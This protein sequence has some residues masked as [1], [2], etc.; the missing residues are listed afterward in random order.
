MTETRYSRN[1]SKANL[2]GFRTFIGAIPELRGDIEDG[3]VVNSIQETNSSQSIRRLDRMQMVPIFAKQE[4][5]VSKLS[6]N[7]G[8]TVNTQLLQ[9]SH[10]NKKVLFKYIR[11]LRNNKLSV[12]TPET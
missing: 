5:S 7:S 8:R 9:C 12:N 11:H 4:T 10:R 1:F 6:V 2:T 3:S